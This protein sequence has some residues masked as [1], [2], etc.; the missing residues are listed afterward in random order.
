MARTEVRGGQILDQ[1]VS[2]TADVSGVLPIAYGG[3]GRTDGSM[4]FTPM[5][6][7]AY[8]RGQLYYDS[9][10][11]ALTFFNFD[12]NVSQQLGQENWL[13][14]RNVTGSTIGN[15][16]PVYVNGADSG[17]PT[18]APCSSSALVSS[19]A[20]GLTTETIPTASAG[21]VTVTG[22]VRGLNTSAYAAGDPLFVGTSPG[23]LVNSVPGGG[24]YSY[25][26]GRVVASNASTGMIHVSPAT[27]VYP[28]TR[29]VTVNAPG[30][31]PSININ[32][33]DQATF[34]GLAV[35]ITSMTTGL[36]GTPSNG[37]KLMLRFKDNGTARAITWGASFVSSGIATLLT[38]TVANRTHH[39][40]LVYDSTKAAW[41]CIAVDAAGYA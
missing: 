39:V 7:Q 20:L 5:A 21:H 36:T 13:R 16:V 1:S 19:M 41:V 12:S 18:V 24:A 23:T 25:W 37:Q 31:T 40:G 8:N 33:V 10:N 28:V 22:L 30:A 27:S 2:L 15:G 9:D 11:E 3:T 26:I 29:D 6:T 14:V 35:A 4:V 34:T 38:T 17:F 32:L